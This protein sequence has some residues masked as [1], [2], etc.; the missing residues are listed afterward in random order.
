MV[1]AMRGSSFG[2][3]GQSVRNDGSQLLLNTFRVGGVIAVVHVV[4]LP[5][6]KRNYQ[7]NLLLRQESPRRAMIL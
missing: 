5:T 3:T 2:I 6:G 7:H 1:I 4:G